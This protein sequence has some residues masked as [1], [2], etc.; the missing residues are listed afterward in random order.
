MS[1][2][3]LVSAALCVS[4]QP[5][6]IKLW[7]RPSTP[8]DFVKALILCAYSSF[9]FGWHVHEKAIMMVTLPAW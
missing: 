2:E 4:S 8:L 9:L 7:K 5:A 6:L 1:Y 3:C